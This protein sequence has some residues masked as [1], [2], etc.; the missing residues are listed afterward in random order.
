MHCLANGFEIL[1][2]AGIQCFEHHRHVEW[3]DRNQ[4]NRIQNAFEKLALVRRGQN[5]SQVLDGEP[6]D[7]QRFDDEEREWFA[8]FTVALVMLGGQFSSSCLLGY[9]HRVRVG[10]ISGAFGLGD[11]RRATDA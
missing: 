9:A 10:L 11:V 8:A 5:A 2:I 6:G 7:A 1:Q 3:H 4:I